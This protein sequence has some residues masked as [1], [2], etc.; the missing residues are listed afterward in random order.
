MSDRMKQI[1]AII[2][3]VRNLDMTPMAAINKI[4]DVLEGIEDT[5]K[6]DGK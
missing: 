2:S 1:E 3:Q 4:S 6:G 5:T